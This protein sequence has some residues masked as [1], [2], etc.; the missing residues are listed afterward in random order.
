MTGAISITLHQEV[1]MVPT[2]VNELLNWLSKNCY[3][4][5]YAI[6]EIKIYEGYGLDFSNGAYVWYYTER[7]QRQNLKH[8]ATEGE[9]VTYAFTIIKADAYANRH[10]IGFVKTEGEFDRIITEL[11]SRGIKYFTD[12]IFYSNQSPSNRYRIF[13]FGCDV[14]KVK[15]LEKEYGYQ[16]F[17]SN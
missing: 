15:D 13:V 17:K 3:A 16:A 9:A 1:N 11:E 8:F 6:G 10:L 12:T 4:N 14:N 2:T 5:N 7:G